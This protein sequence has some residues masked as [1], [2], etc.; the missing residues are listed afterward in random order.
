MLS[1]PA[2]RI[3]QAPAHE[4]GGPI[5]LYVTALPLK[6]LRKHAKVDYWTPDN[7]EGYQRPLVDRRLAEVARYVREEHGILPTSILLCARDNDPDPV[8][9]EASDSYG[10]DLESGK[11]AIPEQAILWVADGQHR[12]FG[13]IRSY[14]RDGLAELENYPFPVTIMTGVDRYAEME[15][16]N[17]VN[18]RQKKMQTDIVDRHL[19]LRAQ[20]EGLKMIARG[21]AGEKEYAR[22]KA[23]RVVDLLNE[24]SGPWHHEIAVPGVAGRDD[25]LVRQHAMV[26]SLEP[27][28]KDPWLSTRSEQELAT[29]ITRYWRALQQTWPEAFEAPSDYR[30]QAT[31]GIYSLHLVLPS[32]IHLGLADHDLSE[33]KM[34]EI[35]KATGIT[36]DFWSKEDGDTLTLGTGM[37]SIRALAEYLR[38]QLPKGAAVTI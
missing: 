31:V 18:T 29:L 30:V 32:V 13:V 10:E 34:T 15:H 38:E 6:E 2:L 36:S 5:T 27:A 9:F 14:E 35:W 23:T 28:L 3:R 22:A 19:V 11:L 24:E 1:V 20:R 33:G 37:A 25:G 17:I 7:P 8:T 26:V 12:L 4:N 21:R 16:F